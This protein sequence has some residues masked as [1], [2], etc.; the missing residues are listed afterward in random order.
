M[1]TT[2]TLAP[3]G[4]TEIFRYVRIVQPRIIDISQRARASSQLKAVLDMRPS[5][6]A[7]W[8]RK[9]LAVNA[10]RDVADL[11][12]DYFAYLS[13][14]ALPDDRLPSRAVV[15]DP[16]AFAA[17]DF[18][19]ERVWRADVDN[20]LASLLAFKIL[21]DEAQA[22]RTAR[23]L[24]FVDLF[25]RLLSAEEER[26]YPVAVLT[27]MEF[28]APPPPPP[29]AQ[30][31]AEQELATDLGKLTKN[32]TVLWAARN[33]LV[34][35]QRSELDQRYKEVLVSAA[36][37]ATTKVAGKTK[38]KAK[39]KSSAKSANALS[40]AALAARIGE[41]RKSM[42]ALRADY[43]AITEAPTLEAVLDMGP[44]L[45]KVDG[46]A[47]TK[48]ATMQRETKELLAKHDITPV[49]FPQVYQQVVAK[50]DTLGVPVASTAA[51]TDC[52]R[53]N[54]RLT[55]GDSVRLLGHADL[56]RVDEAFVKYTPGEISY[57]ENILPGEIK[58]RRVRSTKY[59]E[60]VT[61]T[62]TE[63]TTD[64][65][66]ESSSTTKQDLGSQVATELA[67]RMNTEMSASASGSGGG[68]IGVVDF[69][70]AGSASANLGIGV[71]TSLRTQNTSN[72]SQEIISKAVEKTKKTA[73]E[74]RMT[75]SFSL[76][77][78][79]HSHE[80][81]N[82]VGGDIRA[83]NGI[84]CF[85]D[86]HVCLTETVYGKRLFVMANLHLPGRNLLCAR[87]QR[88]ALGLSELGQRPQFDIT[89]DQIQP[90]TY[91]DY[92]TRY[93]A[94]NVVPPP[95]AI[96]TIAKTY[97]TDTTN[98]NAEKQGMSLSTAASAL[99]PFFAQYKRFLIT[100]NVRLPDGYEVREVTA[101][102]NHGRN[103]V[104]V[105]AHLPLKLLGAAVGSGF[106][107]A[108]G[109]A[110]YYGA[111]ILLPAAVWQFEYAISPLLHYNSDSSN[112][113]LC[114]GNETQD[115]P[116]FFFDPDFLMDELLNAFGNF[117]ESAPDLL[118]TIEGKVEKLITDLQ[119]KASQIPGDVVSIVQDSVNKLIDAV[120]SALSQIRVRK[121][122]SVSLGQIGDVL[123]GAGA[124]SETMKD[125]FKPLGD[126]ITEV[127]QLF[128]DGIA[129]ALGD[130]FDFM[131]SITANSQILT[132]GK[133]NVIGGELPV[134]IN[135]IAINPGITV[136]L[137]VSL[138]RTD[139]ALDK[140]RLDTF[141]ALYQAYAQQLA[142]YE[143][144]AMMLDKSDRITTSPGTMRRQEAAAV[145]ELVLY[146][147]NNYYDP[148]TG[149][150]YGLEKINFFENALDWDNMSFRLF[151][152]GPNAD[153]LDREK[154]GVFIGADDRRQAFLTA[155]WA[156]V[157]VPAQADERLE[158]QV[159]QY[160]VDGSFD[161]EKGFK[162]IDE[163]TA[164]YQTLIT[165]RGRADQPQPKPIG[166]EVLPTDLL[167]I[168]EDL[169]EN[170]ES[171]CA[172]P[173]T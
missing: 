39:A 139:E 96:Q 18:T 118:V 117:L 120:K 164:L 58:K 59:F 50:A 97:K 23:L 122:L 45:L 48:L 56:V 104:S 34:S 73:T 60:E 71:D 127:I 93:K 160:F 147:L 152:Y 20:G 169:P 115:S 108:A 31:T 121:N 25:P 98:A 162:N 26:D 74:R 110:S 4:T 75:R 105:P 137:V 168:Q 66:L 68:T 36:P 158:A 167:Y 80:V 10:V 52:F 22:T 143:N 87:E 165:E 1:A 151:N 69:K 95:P 153:E 2:P 42:T 142:D 163:L 109:L 111:L 155:G 17:H 19:S 6:Q 78:T 144:K 38:A 106:T 91:K 172:A 107:A 114:L 46:S 89:V 126:F 92:V 141:E 49:T 24:S 67:T 15:A 171:P 53:E 134:S 47:A 166:H 150:A 63:E 86:K 8:A 70:G 113:S 12:F 161:F 100:E 157:L 102:V 65:S 83:R 62:T 41:R 138:A 77:E 85:L 32:V 125:F 33:S 112:V 29:A 43:Q 5:E 119:A 149:N 133:T 30:S 79:L 16:K 55:F 37:V 27:K 21:R 3:F 9:R 64:T 81:N 128:R 145:K 99:T 40:K 123:A 11:R 72:F 13:I 28:K 90:W 135:A 61:E 51:G 129:N 14:K 132:F 57:I 103:G 148:A 156:Q 88:L 54:P 76:Y 170:A 94:S 136:N 159:G 84:Y 140:W 44:Q 101:T 146:A 154:Q 130:L 7:A 124:L 82:T 131:K 116:Y 35:K 173:A